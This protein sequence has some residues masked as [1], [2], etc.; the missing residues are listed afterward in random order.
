MIELLQQIT[1]G[2]AVGTYYA[3]I[4]VGMVIIYKTTEVLNFAQGEMGMVCAFFA[5]LILANPPADPWGVAAANYLYQIK[6]S[7]L[8]AFVGAGPQEPSGL[9]MAIFWVR[10]LVATPLGAFIGSVLFAF[11]VGLFIE[12]FFLRRAK[13]PTLLGLIIIT[14]GAEML[15]F[16]LAGWK[17]E[18]SGASLPFLLPELPNLD[19]AGQRLMIGSNLTALLVAVV[20][21]VGLAL[22]FRTKTGVAMKA[23][24]Q[25]LVAA[26]VMGIR[27]NRII[28]LAWAL[29]SVIGALAAVFIAPTDALNKTMMLDPMMHGFAAA[30]LGGM[31]SLVGA[32]LGGYLLGLVKSLLM[33]GIDRGGEM[34]GLSGL[35]FKWGPVIPFVIVVVVL[36]VRPSGLFARHYV[37]KV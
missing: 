13:E 27:T 25:N 30:V 2:I 7:T 8:G 20:V 29:S 6:V 9:A 19:V 1:D 24:Q 36:A 11:G 3:L 28:S 21:M 16:G 26:K 22:F 12:F 5:Y 14:L 35:G 37:K 18:G 33:W 10:S 34:V 31:N 15:L 23:T 17:F 32:A 4:A